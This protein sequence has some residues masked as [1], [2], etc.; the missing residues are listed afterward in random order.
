MSCHSNRQGAL[1]V[2]EGRNEGMIVL[3]L[4]KSSLR[5]IRDRRRWSFHQRI[6]SEPTPPPIPLHPFRL[7]ILA[8]GRTSAP[9]AVNKRSPLTFGS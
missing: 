2:K 6:G 1:L 3:S 4:Q 7:Q 5:R 8:V 9:P